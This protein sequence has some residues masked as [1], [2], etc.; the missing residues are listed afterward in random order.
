MPRLE[1]YREILRVL[2]GHVR[3]GRA[4]YIVVEPVPDGT[5]R[6]RWSEYAAEERKEAVRAFEDVEATT[7]HSRNRQHA[8]PSRVGGRPARRLSQLFRRHPRILRPSTE[9]G[10]PAC[11]GPLA[12]GN[13][14]FNVPMA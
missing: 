11:L 10:W 7:D 1:R 4:V 6:V 14:C 8:R 3:N 5:T 13:S 2:E 9:I 12:D